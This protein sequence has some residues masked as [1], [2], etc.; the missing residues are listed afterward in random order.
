MYKGEKLWEPFINERLENKNIFENHTIK[1]YKLLPDSIYQSFEETVKNLPDKIAVVDNDGEQYSYN[2]LSE[3]VLA[4]AHLL[5]FKKNI[6]P[7]SRV[8]LMLYNGIDFCTAFLALNKLGCAA[9][10]LPTKFKKDEILKLIESTDV[11]DVI[12]DEDFLDYFIGMKNV[13]CIIEFIFCKKNALVDTPVFYNSADPALFMF[14]SG[15]TSLSKVVTLT[16][17]NIMH[18]VVSY[19]KILGITSMDKTI[20]PVP[21]YLITGLVAVFSLIIHVGGSVYINKFFDAKRIL[22]NVQEYGI[23]FFHSSPTAFT[24]LLEHKKNFSELPSLRMLICGGGNMPPD[25]IRQLHSWL[26]EAQ[27]RTVYG[28]TETTS[29][30]TI[31]PSDAAMHKYIGSSGMPIPGLEIKIID[32]R[33]RELPPG[34]EG[35]VFVRGS[36]ITPGYYKSGVISYVDDWLDTGDIGY[37]NSDGFIYIV[38]RRKDM[39]NRGGEKI[40]SFDIENALTDIDGVIDAAV[41]GIPDD[42]YGE[43]PVALIKINSDFALT[44]D[45]VKVQLREKMAGY[46]VPVKII[47]TDN[48]PITSNMKHDKNKIRRMFIGTLEV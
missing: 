20:L 5:Y 33:G 45:N 38:D 37:F 26:P 3:R 25:K 6:K 13:H 9:V 44:E 22:S 30:A 16:N 12:S 35:Y 14:T 42:L 17:Y 8:A 40:C 4:F 29:P 10:P 19:E 48:I 43:V 7:G 11:T 15:T 2:N 31:F 28:L 18:A 46:K 47:F 1:T 41:V 23:T 32:E 36:N 27:F 39:I 34:E 21:M 24:M